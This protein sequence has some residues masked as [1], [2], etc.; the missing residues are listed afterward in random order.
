[1][2][3]NEMIV[4]EKYNFMY[5]PE[6]LKYIGMEGCWHQFEKVDKQGVWAELLETDLAMIERTEKTVHTSEYG[7]MPVLKTIIRT[8][9]PSGMTRNQRKR[10]SK[11]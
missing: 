2:L 6:R 11:K 9:K 3:K 5:Q 4:G 7:S 1:M 8:R 10:Y